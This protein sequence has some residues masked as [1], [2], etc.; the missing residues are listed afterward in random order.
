MADAPHIGTK[1][2]D[3]LPNE[4]IIDYGPW[5]WT[6][7]RTDG[8]LT[9]IT[10]NLKGWKEANITYQATKTITVQGDGDDAGDEHVVTPIDFTATPDVVE[11]FTINIPA[12]HQTTAT[13]HNNNHPHDLDNDKIYAEKLKDW[14]TLIQASVEYTDA[15]SSVKTQLD[16]L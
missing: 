7:N 5:T 2:V 10:V 8:T 6:E 11:S 13:Y 3:V 14:R 15:L 1:G 16:S 12:D 9:S 4:D